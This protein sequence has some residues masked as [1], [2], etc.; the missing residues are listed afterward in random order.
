MGFVGL[1]ALVLSVSCST[2]SGGGALQLRIAENATDLFHQRLTEERFEDIVDS[3]DDVFRS[4]APKELIMA[5]MRET[6]EQLGELLSSERVGAACVGGEV[7]LV[8]HSKY[9]NYDTTEMFRWR[10]EGTRGALVQY[11]VSRGFV[12]VA[13]NSFNECR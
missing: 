13:V 5:K 12:E 11:Q 7:R 2:S 3:G 8:F 1:G 9:R 6:R 4:V 10:I